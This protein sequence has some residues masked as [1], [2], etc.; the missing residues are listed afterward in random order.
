[1]GNAGRNTFHGPGYNCWEIGLYKDT[2]ITENTKIELRLET[3]NT[4][5]HTQFQNPASDINSPTFGQVFAAQAP[6]ILQLAA[7]FIF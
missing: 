5:N 7:K 2:K 6:R 3:F 4:F 1:M